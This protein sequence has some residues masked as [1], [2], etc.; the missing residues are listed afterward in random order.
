MPLSESLWHEGSLPDGLS[1]SH[2]D[3]VFGFPT[4]CACRAR[5]E[6]TPPNAIKDKSMP[7][8]NPIAKTDRMTPNRV[9]P[10][11]FTRWFLL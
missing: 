1:L 3:P 8:A 5:G 4:N 10:L 9:L 7:R 6:D 11:L 2:V